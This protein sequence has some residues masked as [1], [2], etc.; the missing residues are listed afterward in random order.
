TEAEKAAENRRMVV[1][2]LMEQVRDV[3]W[4]VEEEGNAERTNI[5][6][7]ELNSYLDPVLINNKEDLYTLYEIEKLE[8]L[9]ISERIKTA[10]DK[11]HQS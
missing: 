10:N 5:F 9:M 3:Y 7:R 8:M 1:N 11:L 6:I 2:G 4:K